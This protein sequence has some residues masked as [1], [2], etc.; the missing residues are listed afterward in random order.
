[1]Q[2]NGIV[3]KT[4]SMMRDSCWCKNI[5]GLPPSWGSLAILQKVNSYKKWKY[6]FSKFVIYFCKKGKTKQSSVLIS[7]SPDYGCCRESAMTGLHSLSF[8]WM[9]KRLC[10]KWIFCLCFSLPC[11]LSGPP[12]VILT[13]LCLSD[14]LIH[15]SYWLNWLVPS[16]LACISFTTLLATGVFSFDSLPLIYQMGVNLCRFRKQ[17]LSE[18][19]T[20][21]LRS[22]ISCLSS[23]T[24]LQRRSV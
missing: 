3:R 1:M 5:G 7:D 22:N 10:L 24:T 6:V 4:M 11:P 12:P 17:C 20:V 16:E 14:C 8:Q 15:L 18:T 21:L 13:L 9:N 23:H 2:S 19:A